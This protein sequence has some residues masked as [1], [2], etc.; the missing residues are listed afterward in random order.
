[1]PYNDVSINKGNA[2]LQLIDTYSIPSYALSYLV[3]G[4]ASGIEDSDQDE[5]D[6]WLNTELAEYESIVYDMA[7]DAEPS[8]TSQPAFGLPVDCIECKVHGHP[9]SVGDSDGREYSNRQDIDTYC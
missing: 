6:N 4:D 3:N 1:M 2:M 7:D 5:I 9:A 8:F